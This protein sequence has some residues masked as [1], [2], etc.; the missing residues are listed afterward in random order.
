MNQQRVCTTRY[1]FT[2]IQFCPAALLLLRTT[3]YGEKQQNQNH[4]L[5]K[6]L[7]LLYNSVRFSY[8]D[9]TRATAGIHSMALIK[10]EALRNGV[11][12][13]GKLI[14]DYQTYFSFKFSTVIIVSIGAVH[15]TMTHGD[16]PG[17]FSTVLLF[18]CLLKQI[19]IKIIRNILLH[20][21]SM[22]QNAG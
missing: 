15:G 8:L 16:N 18:I 7:L 22:G 14:Q 3:R 2:H 19:E 1:A 20:I 12:I 6:L 13:K 5:L 9:D 11:W 4:I 10:S 21:I 17:I